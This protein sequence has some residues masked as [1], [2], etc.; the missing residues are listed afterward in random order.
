MEEVIGFSVA[1]ILGIIIGLM[2]SVSVESHSIMRDAY[3]RGLATECLGI[4]GYHFEC[5]D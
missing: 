1:V 3:Q 5:P 2:I 4:T